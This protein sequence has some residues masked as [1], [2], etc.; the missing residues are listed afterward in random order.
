MPGRPTNTW[1]GIGNSSDPWNYDPEVVYK[2]Q[3]RLSTFKNQQ[4]LVRPFAKQLP[5][6]KYGS[7]YGKHLDED[8]YADPLMPTM[9]ERESMRIRSCTSELGQRNSD[10]V[11]TLKS[12]K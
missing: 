8:H 1:I 4:S 7:I 12:F 10:H 6:T 9:E 3:T 2:A 5:R 11:N